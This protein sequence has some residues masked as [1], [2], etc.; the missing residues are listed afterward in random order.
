MNRIDKEK[1]IVTQMIRLYCHRKERNSTLCPECQELLSYALAR[2]D[3]CKFG[4]RKKSCK[5][6]PIHCYKP[7]MKKR[8]RE[9]MKWAGPR[10][11][12]YHPLETIKHLF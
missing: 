8:I 5:K 1:K 6:C 4:E 9:V 3:H 7:N 11:I 10:M 12:F 2:L